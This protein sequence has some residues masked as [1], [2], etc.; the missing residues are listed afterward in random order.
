MLE[1][2]C[3][4]IGTSSQADRSHEREPVWTLSRLSEQSFADEDLSD[5]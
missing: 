3:H 1:Q 4:S 2:I 5:A